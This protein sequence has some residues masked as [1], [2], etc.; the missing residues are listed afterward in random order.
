MRRALT[1]IELIFTIV[2]ISFVFTVVPKMFQISNKSISFSSKED[3]LFNM[4]AQIMDIVVKEYDENNTEYDD[5]LLSSKDSILECNTTT[6]YRVGGFRGS[7]NCFN[8]IDESSIGLDSD[9]PPRDDI[10]DYNGLNYSIISGHKEY[11]LSIVVGY[12]DNWNTGDYSDNKLEF[13][14]TNRSDNN[15][16]HIKRV[17]VRVFDEDENISSVYYYSA[18]IGHIEIKSIIW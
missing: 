10:D 4:Y 8:Q 17:Y 3:A 15:T 13:N 16:S 1:L 5:I 14:F 18:N 6:G 9:E 7:R 11:N 12:S 2:I